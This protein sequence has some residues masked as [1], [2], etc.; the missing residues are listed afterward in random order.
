M[1]HINPPTINEAPWWNY[2]GK[3]IKRFAST[4]VRKRLFRIHLKAC[5]ATATG[6][7]DHGTAR[8][9]IGPVT[10]G[11]LFERLILWDASIHGVDLDFQF[12]QEK[13]TA[14]AQT[15][16]INFPRRKLVAAN[17][18][19]N[20]THGVTYQPKSRCFESGD[21]FCLVPD[22]G[23][24]FILVVLQVTIAKDHPIKEKGLRD[25]LSMFSGDIRKQISQHY[26]AFVTDCDSELNTTQYFH[27]PARQKV[28][29]NSWV[30]C[31]KQLVY[32]H[33]FTHTQ[34]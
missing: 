29:E 1:I 34:K 3:V 18:L 26:V 10:S 22:D 31:F 4:Y 15:R 32:R 27:T 33:S 13:P 16:V 6:L 2:S 17:Q 8:Y 20:L 14:S 21:A 5:V 25:I 24:K 19:T 12:L 30:H 11:H 23:G 28:E 9:T 7:F